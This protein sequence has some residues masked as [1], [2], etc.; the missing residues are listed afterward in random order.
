MLS[1]NM[2]SV[3]YDAVHDEIIVPNRLAGAVLTFRGSAKG[4]EP[5]LRV[6]VGP[7]TTIEA[8][9]FLTYEP[10]HE[11]IYVPN[12]DEILVFSRLANGNAA[13]I[14][15]FHGN[16]IIS[17][18]AVDGVHDVI[19]ARGSVGGGGKNGILT[20]NRTDQG[21]VKPRSFIGGPHTGIESAN[22]IQIYPEK[23]WIV[24]AQSAAEDL[25]PSAKGGRREPYSIGVWSINDKGD[26]PPRWELGGPATTLQRGRRVAL[27]PKYK[28]ILV[29]DMWQNAILTF[30]FPELF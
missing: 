29:A 6:I 4:E 2:H 20:F 9:L 1:R 26:V 22:S 30:Y 3:H 17:D 5:P 21:E 7:K 8:P 27:V 10:I 11:E 16:W 14:R 23:G 15:E 12:T 28:E 24:I 18:L 19:A 13:P 25:G